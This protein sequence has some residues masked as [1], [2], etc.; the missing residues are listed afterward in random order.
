MTSQIAISKEQNLMAHQTIT[1]KWDHSN[2]VTVEPNPC[3]LAIGDTV[4][5]EAFP[6]AQTRVRFE[7][8]SS[9]SEEAVFEV[10]GSEI[11]HVIKEGDFSFKCVVIGPDGKQHDG[12]GGG[13]IHH[14]HGT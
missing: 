2:T 7:Q 11:C 8:G 5:F 9:F 12:G 14:P 3:I 10:R 13:H 1:L 4:N 6:D